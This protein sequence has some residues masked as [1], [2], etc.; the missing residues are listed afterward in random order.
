MKRCKIQN[1]HVCICVHTGEYVDMIWLAGDVT[2]LSAED[3]EC[4]AKFSAS[5]GDMSAVLSALE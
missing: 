3:C 4:P 1:L 5:E 2:R